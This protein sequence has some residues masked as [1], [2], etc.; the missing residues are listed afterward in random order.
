[1]KKK[2]SIY[3]IAKYSGVSPAAVSYVINGVN[4]VSEE[5]KI[6][7]LAAIEELGYVPDHNAR[8]LS[9]GKSHLIGLF[10]PLNDA[11]IAFLQNPFYVEFIGGLEQG[12]A[13]YDYDIVIGCQKNQY[14][15]KDWAIS[16][17]LDGVVMLGTYPKNVY[18]DIKKLNIPVALTDVYED[19]SK[20]FH[21]IRIDDE[22]GTY[23]ATKHLIENGHTKIGFV[24]CRDL[25]FVDKQRYD[26]YVKAM[27]EHDL[28]ISE[29]AFYHSF[30]TF[31]DGIK[32]ADNI[33]IKNN[34]TAIVCAA[35][36]I[37]IGIIR[38]YIEKGKKVPEDLSV[39]GFDDI[40]DAKYIYPGLTTVHQDIGKKGKLAAELILKSLRDKVN[41][42]SLVIT[43]PSLVIRESVKKIN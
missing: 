32:V 37:A 36:I 43:E 23:I 4:K 35:D 38:R 6:R 29:D 3:D 24:G 22:K 13:N 21:N 8:S 41:E 2:I 33:M 5:T 40:Q 15:F 14:N 9:T 20:E 26:G 1:M 17:G 42:A 34:V 18:D 31:D 10:L 12:I 27:K 28:S 7:V 11:S 39:V 30:A 25:S 16:R 19:Y